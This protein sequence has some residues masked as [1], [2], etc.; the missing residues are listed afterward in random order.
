MS[1][2]V[3]SN[4][5]KSGIDIYKLNGMVDNTCTI[6][7]YYICLF[8]TRAI[9]KGLTL[10]KIVFDVYVCMFC[11]ILSG[12]LALKRFGCVLIDKEHDSGG[13]GGG[14]GGGVN[15][16]VQKSNKAYVH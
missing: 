11:C 6:S 12:C 16:H 4:F 9:V 8:L 2:L 15:I 5:D 3:S 13:G 1:I 7:P 10:K 14:G